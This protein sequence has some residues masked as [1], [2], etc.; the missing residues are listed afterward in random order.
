M[1]FKKFF[2]IPLI[3]MITAI[4]VGIILG[5]FSDIPIDPKITKVEF[6]TIFLHNAFLS[7]I[8]FLGG[9][10]SFSLISHTILVINGV[11]TGFILAKLW[12]LTDRT[13]LYW[14]IIPHGILELIAYIIFTSASFYVSFTF[15]QFIKS[16]LSKS[17]S[18]ILQKGFYKTTAIL[19]VLGVIFLF[20]AAI[21]EVYII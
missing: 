21:V 10:I 13:N 6:S 4:I 12:N 17:K 2:F 8:I 19:L 16:K 14:H 9:I 11:T 7:I 1:K 18:F 5:F 20:L 15:Y 3:V